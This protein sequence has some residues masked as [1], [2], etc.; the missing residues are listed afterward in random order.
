MVDDWPNYNESL[1]MR[2]E[3]LLDLTLLRTWGDELHKMNLGKEGARYR[4]PE[5]LITLQAFIR[6]YLRLLYRQL[7]GLT[8]RLSQWEPRLETPDYSTTCRRID[9]LDVDLELV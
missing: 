5:T 6:A 2:G 7:E 3:I 4:I 8:R 9:N 1:A